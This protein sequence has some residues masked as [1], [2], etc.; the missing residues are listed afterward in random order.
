MHASRHDSIAANALATVERAS[1]LSQ[2]K[3]AVF[4]RGVGGT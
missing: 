2:A 3:K 4:R 1:V